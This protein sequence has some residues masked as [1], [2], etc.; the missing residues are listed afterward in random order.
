MLVYPVK[1]RGQK[2]IKVYLPKGSAWVDFYTKKIYEGGTT[3]KIAL[4]I[5]HIPVFVRVG[6]F[7]PMTYG[8]KNTEAWE[9]Q[10][11]EVAYYYDTDKKDSER[12]FYFD[13]GLLAN[14]YEKGAFE[15]I[16]FEAE[17]EKNIL[18]ID[19]ESE[20]GPNYMATEKNITFV[21]Y[22]LPK[23]PKNVSYRGKKIAYDYDPKTLTFSTK[24]KF[25]AKETALKIKL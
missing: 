21:V 24:I 16:N 5:S 9:K 25:T 18:E 12:D 3:H 17:Y 4:D 19:I 15:I 11:L 10:P 20:V 23:K 22:N 8:I 6:A 2:D 14:A 1:N 7:I 13:N